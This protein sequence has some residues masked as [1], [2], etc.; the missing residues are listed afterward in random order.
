MYSLETRKIVVNIYNQIKNLRKV[1]LLKNIS[2][3]TISRYNKSVLP[4]KRK[5]EIIILT[6]LIITTYQIK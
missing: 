5:T 2:K 3:S 6:P 1:E 4:A